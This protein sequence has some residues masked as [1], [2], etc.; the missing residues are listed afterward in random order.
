MAAQLRRCWKVQLALGKAA[1][2][3]HDQTMA[4]AAFKAASNLDPESP[5]P[6]YLL[7]RIYTAQRQDQLAQQEIAIFKRLRQLYYGSLSKTLPWGF[8]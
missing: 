8:L 6:H 1:W 7:S 4:L 3:M 5:E 2:A